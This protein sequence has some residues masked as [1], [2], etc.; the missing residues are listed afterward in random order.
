MGDKNSVIIKIKRVVIALK[1]CLEGKKK[2]KTLKDS[3]PF[4]RKSMESSRLLS[5][6]QTF[7]EP[8]KTLSLMGNH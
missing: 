6:P 5:F 7:G 3:F 4:K 1:L 8:N 2:G